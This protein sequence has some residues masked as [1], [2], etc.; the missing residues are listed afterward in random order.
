MSGKYENNKIRKKN[1]LPVILLAAATV[2]I[3]LMVF[4]L[5]TDK[6]TV[7][8]DLQNIEQV[9]TQQQTEPATLPRQSLRNDMEVLDI[10]GY[11][12]IYMEDGTDEIV[13]DVLMM[14][15]R[16]NGEDT[17]QYA[18]ITVDIGEETA[19]FTVSTLLPGSTVVLLEQNR[20]GFDETVDYSSAY[21]VCENLALFQ[22]PLSVQEDKISV[23]MLDFHSFR[24]LKQW[25]L[26]AVS[27]LRFANCTNDFVSR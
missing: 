17:V 21:V 25:I 9:S 12:G 16:N 6:N 8:R 2:L 4:F 10:G 24:V 11:T 27:A 1:K 26:T 14:K 3:A 20:M 13:S 23:Q 19:E 18:K 22:E 7:L 5:Q 15:L